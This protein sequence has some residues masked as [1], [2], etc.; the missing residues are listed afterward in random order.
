MDK[1]AV[2]PARQGHVKVVLKL[3]FRKLILEIN[4]VLVATALETEKRVATT[5][6]I[7]FSYY[8]I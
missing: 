3:W 2:S 6:G 5:P 8:N 1:I 4:L 7:W